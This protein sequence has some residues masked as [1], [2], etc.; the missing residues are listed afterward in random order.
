MTYPVTV[1]LCLPESAPEL[2]ALQREGVIFLLRKGLDS[3]DAVEG[4]DGMEVEFLDDAIAV[5]PGG[6]LLR[7]FVDAPALEFAE[8]AVRAVVAG[9][10]ERSEL[11]A[12]WEIA[13]CE[14]QLHPDLARE[15]LEAADGPDAPP[16][17]PAERARRH[18]DTGTVG[19]PGRLNEAEV[20]AMRQKLRSFAQRLQS[21]PLESFGYSDDEEERV[22]SREAAE[23]AAG[24]LVYA[25]DLLVDELFLDLASLGKDGP[26]VA[27][28]ERVFMVLEELPPQFAL[29][30]TVLF[31]RRLIATAITMTGRLTQ[32]HFGML[33]CVAEELLLRILLTKAEVTVDLYGL[34]SDEVST[35]W[36]VFADGVYED[37]DHEWLYDPAADGIDKDPAS[38]HLGIAPMGVKD[39]FTPFGDKRHVHPYAANG[40][41]EEQAEQPEGQP[42]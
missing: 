27:E 9:L 5:H 11:L 15:S 26:N 22:V 25:I 34:L 8:D 42:E 21:F 18:A 12:D 38:A 16:A 1:D 33:T 41:E 20:E 35:A 40:E 29:Q 17:D 10:L 31:T 30:Y 39:W 36:E 7:L 4:P 3:I 23:I 14:V 37:M 32:S 2:D 6:A 28:S 19:E 24:A 13:Q